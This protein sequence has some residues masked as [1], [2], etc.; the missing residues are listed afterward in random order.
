M[1]IEA[2]IYTALRSLVSD[3]VFPDVAPVST[4]RPYITYQQIGGEVINPLTG[5][6]DKQNGF[7][8]INVWADT[9][10]AA[11]ALA[12]QVETAMRSATAFAAR[13]MAAPIANHEPDLSLYGAIQDFSVWS[14]KA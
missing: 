5:D 12:L 11:A 9:R 14:S 10:A 6:P 4:A 7:F 1:T 13:P 8:Q 2:S 3:R